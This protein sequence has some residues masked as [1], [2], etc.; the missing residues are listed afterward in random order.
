MA[1]APFFQLRAEKEIPV[2]EKKKKELEEKLSQV[3]DQH[4]ELM[5]VSDQLGKVVEELDAKSLRWLEL[6]E[7]L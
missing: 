2:L 7:L 4:N 1:S 6:S 5:A 3:L